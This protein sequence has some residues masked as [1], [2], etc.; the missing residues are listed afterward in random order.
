MTV[1]SALIPALSVYW[2]IRGM[3]DHR[4]VLF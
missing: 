2:R 4:V 1:T 3:L